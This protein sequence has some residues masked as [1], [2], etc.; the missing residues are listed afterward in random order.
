MKQVKIPA[1]SNKRPHPSRK[2][3]KGGGACV[4]LLRQWP[5]S[6]SHVKR[7]TKGTWF[8]EPGRQ[9]VSWF[10]IYTAGPKTFSFKLA[11]YQSYTY[12][13]MYMLTDV[14]RCVHTDPMYAHIFKC[15][16]MHMYVHTYI[17]TCTYVES[18]G[19]LPCHI[20]MDDS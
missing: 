14:C 20:R 18:E 16:Y 13:Y 3:R 7:P 11:E 19:S 4:S 17:C 15:A 5:I 12:T 2:A 1:Y 6:L 9:D 8:T 10:E